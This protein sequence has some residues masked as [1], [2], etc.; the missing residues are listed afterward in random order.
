MVVTKKTITRIICFGLTI[1]IIVGIRF[2][3]V[4]ANAQRSNYKNKIS[5]CQAVIN[6]MDS[7]ASL[8][9][10]QNKSL[11]ANRRRMKKCHFI[12]SQQVKWAGILASIIHQL[13]QN[14]WLKKI[15]IQKQ[16]SDPMF[17]KT[18]TK[19]K[20]QKQEQYAVVIFGRSVTSESADLFAE[21]LV[22]SGILKNILVRENRHI[23]FAW[24]FKIECKLD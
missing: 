10:K 6:L 9:R 2:L 18:N 14:V 1:L 3:D 19:V 23:D 20:F 8:L 22:E 7:E 15:T 11:H 4:S 16:K 21:M 17:L 12:S 24:Q 13:P 5:E